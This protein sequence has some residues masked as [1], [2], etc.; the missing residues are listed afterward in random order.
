[1]PQPFISVLSA[2]LTHDNLCWRPILKPTFHNLLPGKHT[3]T[4]QACLPCHAL[5]QPAQ[6]EQQLAYHLGTA[7]QHRRSEGA[8][9]AA[10]AAAAATADSAGRCGSEGAVLRLSGQVGGTGVGQFL[11]NP[12]VG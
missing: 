4:K 1:M 7:P 11:A 3:H 12:H 9:A 10:A 5:Q 2:M 8:V 6:D